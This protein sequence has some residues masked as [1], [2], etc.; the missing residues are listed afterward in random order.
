MPQATQFQDADKYSKY[1]ATCPGRLRSDLARQYL[2]RFLPNPASQRRV[3]DLGG[4]TGAMSA[5]LAKDGFQVV[6][7]DSS[8]EMLRISRKEAEGAQVG[9]RITFCQADA[10]QVRQLFAPNSFDIVI[11]H[12]LLEYVAD[13]SEIVQSITYI[14]REDGVFS[15]LVRNRAGEVFKAAVKSS[16]WRLAR[17]TLSAHTV[18]DSLFGKPVRL[19]DPPE[20]REMLAE[21]GLNVVAQFGVRV[22]SDYR[23]TAPADPA[24]ETYAHLLDLEF[25]LGSHPQFAAIA[26]YIQIIARHSRSSQMSER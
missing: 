15:L 17:E 2:E 16:D 3:L 9:D 18:L 7:L 1:L 20:I 21:A 23:E 26:R 12:N 5:R 22:F 13:P 8:D 6:L 4:G 14:L 25:T 19:F 11:C 24:P 10:D